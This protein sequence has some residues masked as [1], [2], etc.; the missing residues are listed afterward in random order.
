MLAKDMTAAHSQ[1]EIFGMW[2]KEIPGLIP[3]WTEMYYGE[4]FY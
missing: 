3:G 2:T 4:L 1:D